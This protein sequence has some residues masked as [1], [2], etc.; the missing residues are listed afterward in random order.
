MNCFL[1]T[2]LEVKNIDNYTDLK[3]FLSSCKNIKVLENHNFLVLSRDI[4]VNNISKIDYNSYF[5][6]ISKEPFR[7]INTMYDYVYFNTDC[8]NLLCKSK[9]L[10]Y[11][12]DMYE[13]LDGDTYTI[14]YYKEKWF[15]VSLKNLDS[16]AN[17]NILSQAVDIELLLSNLNPNQIYTFKLLNS[18]S[19][20]L[21]DY[22][23][24]YGSDHMKLFHISSKLDRIYLDIS[25]KPLKEF[26]VEYRKI[27]TDFNILDIDDKTLTNPKIK[28]LEIDIY[29]NSEYYHFIL[30]CKNYIYA[31]KLKP[32]K[33][34]YR[35]FLKLYQKNLLENHI[36]KYNMNES[37]QNSRIPYE[38]YKTEDVLEISF[39]ILAYEL[40]ELFKLVWNIRDTSHRDTQLYNFLPT[41]YKVLLYRVKGIYFQ[42]RQDN[43]I[44]EDNEY[45][46]ENN[47]F[48]YLKNVEIELLLKLFLSRRKIKY[49]LEKKN[50][51]PSIY[52][53]FKQITSKEKKLDLKMMAILTNYLYP[54]IRKVEV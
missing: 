7:L 22:T 46:D 43:K 45:L 16:D 31:K 18:K 41:E 8:I 53:S 9:L 40:F 26:N 24:R 30:D 1:K 15:F 39:K 37:I 10:N 27:I 11:T 12:F 3:S 13:S 28:G 19:D 32:D 44:S 17:Y 2:M 54:E 36:I 51:L 35:S 29:I 48:D 47:I 14:F 25:N 6:I 20:T 21:V 38:S 52:N 4:D 34:K 23:K 49:I 33:N 5:T 42:N 50:T